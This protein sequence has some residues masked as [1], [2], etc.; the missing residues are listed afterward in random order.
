[1][2]ADLAAGNA[3]GY[4]FRYRILPA[5][6]DDEAMFEVAATPDEYGKTGKRSFF[7]DAEGK[8]HGADKHGAVAMPADPLLEGDKSAESP[9]N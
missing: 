1:V 7:L 6:K 4:K 3:A 5:E 2:S 8:V 9:Q